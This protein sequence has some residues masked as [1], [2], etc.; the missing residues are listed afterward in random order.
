MTTRVLKP[1]SYSPPGLNEVALGISVP[2]KWME[3]MSRIIG[4]AA[5]E[6]LCLVWAVGE[7][8]ALSSSAW[9]VDALKMRDVGIDVDTAAQER[10]LTKREDDQTSAT[11]CPH[12][13][14]SCSAP[15]RLLRLGS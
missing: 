6:R 8:M 3:L 2:K 14:P 4:G 13:M 11:T 10:T 15:G 9:A 5:T 1:N 12:R 7:R